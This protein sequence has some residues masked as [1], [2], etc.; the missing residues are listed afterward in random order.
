MTNRLNFAFLH[1]GGQGSWVWQE[2]ISELKT[3]AGEN[4][5]SVVTLDVPGCGEKRD[6]DTKDLTVTDIIDELIADLD[7]ANIKDVILVGH[8]QAGNVMPYMAEKRPDLFR[9]LVYVTCSIPLPGQSVIEMVGDKIQ[10]SDD[11]TVGWPVDP[12]TTG[13]RERTEI[14]FCN[15]MDAEETTCFMA[16]LGKDQWPAES[17]SERNWQIKPVESVPAIYIVCLQDKILPVSWQERFADRF[18]AQKILRV[19]A[20]HQAMNTQPKL[21][22]K[23]IL[24]ECSLTA[25]SK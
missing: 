25:S 12:K 7:K 17:Y 1:G 24:E 22:A 16:K 6:R 8:S 15:D 11:N 23:T 9:S 19:D 3:L 21:L 2:T 13:I 20:G 18:Y 5:G 4:L 10:G 14:M